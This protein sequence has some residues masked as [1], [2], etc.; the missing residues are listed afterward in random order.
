MAILV[1]RALRARGGS[2]RAATITA[3]ISYA[4][5]LELLQIPVPGRGFEILDI[6]VAG[7]G[8]LAAVGL[9]GILVRPTRVQG[10]DLARR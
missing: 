10:A 5:L 7:L 9:A 4:I 1:Q 6:V 8:V 3:C 2:A